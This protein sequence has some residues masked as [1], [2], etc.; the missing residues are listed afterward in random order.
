MQNADLI[1]HVNILQI[2]TSMFQIKLLSSIYLLLYSDPYFENNRVPDLEKS[3]DHVVQGKAFMYVDPTRHFWLYRLFHPQKVLA[4][5]FSH[6]LKVSK[7]IFTL[8]ALG[9]HML[10]VHKSTSTRAQIYPCSSLVM[11]NGKDGI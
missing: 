8:S 10:L 3:L 1:N 2:G 6:P 4:M 5:R 7:R 11:L 9:S